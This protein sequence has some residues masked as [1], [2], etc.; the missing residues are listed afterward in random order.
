MPSSTCAV[1]GL[2]DILCESTP[3]SQRVLTKV[4]RPVPEAPGNAGQT[5]ER[6]GE[7]GGQDE[8]TDD[9]EGELDTLFNAFASPGGHVEIGGE[10]AAEKE[11]C[12]GKYSV[13]CPLA[14]TTLVDVP[15]TLDS[16]YNTRSL[17]LKITALE[18]PL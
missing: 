2:S 12:D 9:H 5:A 1:S 6:A 7:D 4:V 14:P 11:S 15:R 16:C 17:F 13:E 8:L 3:D 18:I 10:G